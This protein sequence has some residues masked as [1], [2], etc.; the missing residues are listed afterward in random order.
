LSV[1]LCELE[2]GNFTLI[3]AYK[4]EVCVKENVDQ[5]IQAKNKSFFHI[6]LLNSKWYHI[7]QQKRL[8]CL[9]CILIKTNVSKR[10]F[11]GVFCMYAD[12]RRLEYPR[13]IERRNI[14]NLFCSN[15]DLYEE[16]QKKKKD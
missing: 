16:N 5:K 14:H 7:Q 6:S 8:L 11:C 13:Y 15:L 1:Y 10:A 4:M 2:T 12:Q 9:L 3:K